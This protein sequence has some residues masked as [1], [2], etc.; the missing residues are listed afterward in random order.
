MKS[1]TDL[2]DAPRGKSGTMRIGKYSGSKEGLRARADGH[3]VLREVL[4][5]RVP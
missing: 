2:V 5:V 4:A 3:L 1:E